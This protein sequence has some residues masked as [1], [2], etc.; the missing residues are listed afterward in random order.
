MQ[1]VYD[2][3]HQAYGEKMTITILVIL[4]SLFVTGHLIAQRPIE[5][6]VFC[7]VDRHRIQKKSLLESDILSCARIKYT[8]PE[9]V[10]EKASLT[11]T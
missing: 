7:N 3:L 8:G 6:F 5:H 1:G 11:S 10:P 9:L 4:T 2:L